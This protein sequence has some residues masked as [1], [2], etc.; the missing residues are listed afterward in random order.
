MEASLRI[1]TTGENNEQISFPNQEKPIVIHEY[2]YNAQRMGGTPQISFSFTYDECLDNVWTGNEYIVFKGEKYFIDSTPSVEKSNSDARYSYDVTCYSERNILNTV[3]F[4]DVVTQEDDTQIRGTLSFQFNGNIAEFAKR[5]SESM[6]INGVDYSVVVD[7][8][9]ETEYKNISFEHKYFSE[10]INEIYNTYKLRYYF[11][12]K[13]CHVGDSNNTVDHIFEYGS[14]EGLLSVNH[15]NQNASVITRIWGNG[16]SDNIPYYYPNPTGKGT[17]TIVADENNEGASTDD[18][19]VIDQVKFAEKVALSD[20]LYYE[21]ADATNVWVTLDYPETTHRFKTYIINEPDGNYSGRAYIDRLSITYGQLYTDYNKFYLK[22]ELTTL[23]KNTKLNWSLSIIC[24]LLRIPSFGG[25]PPDLTRPFQFSGIVVKINITNETGD[26][27]YNYEHTFEIQDKGDSTFRYAFNEKAEFITLFKTP[28]K[29]I[30]DGTIE[31]AYI[32]PV[33]SWKFYWMRIEPLS[34]IGF[35]FYSDLDKTVGLYINGDADRKYNLDELG[36]KINSLHYGDKFYQKQVKYITPSDKLMPSIYRES[37]GKEAFY[38]A[39]NNT[40]KVDGKENEYYLFSEEF[41]E[42]KP[43]DG[44]QE[45]EEIKPSIEGMTNAAGQPMTQFLDFAYDTNDSDEID[46]ETNKYLHPYF[47][48]KLPKTNGS[49]GFNLFSQVNEKETMKISFTSGALA[50]CTFEIGV[51]DNT[52]KNTVQVNT[53]GSLQRDE[54]GNVLCGREDVQ[55][56]VEPQDRQNDTLNNEVWIAL[57]KDDSSYSYVM[58]NV[59]RNYKPTTNDTFVILGITMPE[60]YIIAAEKKLDEK[61]ISY[62]SD[63]NFE[64]FSFS[65]S[66]SRIFLA[67]HPDITEQIDENS[68][69]KIRYN[70][71]EYELFI[72]SYTYTKKA[73]DVLP[74]IKVNLTDNMVVSS[75]SLNTAV[76]NAVQNSMTSL[77]NSAVQGEA[78]NQLQTMLQNFLRKDINDVAN[79]TITFLRNVFFGQGGNY[80]IGSDGIASLFNV[81]LSGKIDV[82]NF[83]QGISG[84]RISSDGIARFISLFLSNGVRSTDFNAGVLGTG[85]CLQKDENGDSY[86][87]VDRMLVRKIATFVQLMIQEIKHVGGQIIL[88]PAAMK[89]SNVEAIM[90]NVLRD[91]NGEIL[92]DSNGEMLTDNTDT[93]VVTA[94]RCYFDKSDGERTIYNEFVVGDQVRCQTFNVETGNI[95]YAGNTYYWRLVVGV[96]EDYIDLSVDDCDEGSGIPVIG[97]ELVQLGNRTD[98]T[99]QNA[100]ILS[101]Y[102]EGSPSFIQYKGIN[103]YQLTEDMIVSKISP[104]GNYLK[105]TLVIEAA[106]GDKNVYDELYKINTNLTDGLKEIDEKYSF[107]ETLKEEFEIA[108]AQIDGSITTW[109]YDPVPTLDNAPA[110]EWDTVELKNQH[111]GDLYY[112]G[113]GRAY[114]FQMSGDDYIWQEIVD[115]DITLALEKAKNAQDT[116][117]GKRRVFVNTPTNKSAYDPGDLWV[118]ATYEDIYINDLLRCNTK[119]AEDEPWKISHWEKASKYTDDTLAKAAAKAAEDA[120]KAADNANIDLTNFKSDDIISP[121]E[122]TSLEQ[123]MSDIRSEYNEIIANANRYDIDSTNYKT[124]YDAAIAALTKYTSVSPEFINIEADYNNISAYYSARQTILDAIAI[125]THNLVNQ[126]VQDAARAGHYYLDLTNDVAAVS[127]DSEGNVIGTLPNSKAIVYYGTSVDTGW[128]YKGTFS[129][130]SGSVNST[131]GQITLSAVSADNASVTVT[132]TKADCPELTNVFSISKVRQGTV[133]RGI[134]QTDVTYKASSSGTTVPGGTWSTSVPTVPEGQFLWTRTII[135]YNDG[136]DSTSYSVGKIGSTGQPGADGDGIVSVSTTYQIGTSGTTPPSGTWNASVPSPQ[137]GKYLWTRT[138]TSYKQG[139]P[140]TT[141]GVSYYGTDGTAA[142]YVRL[143]GDQTFVYS[144]N[145]S[146]NPTP[147]SIKLTATLTG[148]SG[149]QWSYKRASQSSFTNISGATSQTY[150]LSHNNST[151]WGSDKSVTL[152]CTSGGVHDEMTVVKVSS[153]SNGANGKDA[154]T[155]ILSNESHAFQGTNNAAIAA[156]VKCDVIAYKGAARVAAT[157]GDITGEPSGMTTS[158]SGNGSTTAAF[159]VSVTSAFTT[160]NG[161]L[162]IPITVDGQSFT[163][164]FSFSIAFKGESGV[165]VESVANKYAV[166][167]SNTTAPTSWSDNVPTMTTTNKYLWNYEIITY[168]NGSTD[169]TQKRVIGVHGNTGTAGNGIKSISERY[170][171]STSSSGVTTSTSGWTET[172]QTTTSSKRYLWNYEIITY[173]NG[174]RHTSTPVVIGTYG[175]KG[176]AAV[177][178][179]IEPSVTVVKRNMDD[180]ISADTVTCKKYKTTGNTARVE[181]TEKTLKYQRIGQDAS[182]QNYSGAVAVTSSTTMIVFT[183]YDGS[184]VLDRENVPVLLDASGIDLNTRNYANGT[185][186][187]I[188]IKTFLNMNNQVAK[189]EYNCTGLKT[190][191]T[192]TISF[193]YEASG[194]TFGDGAMIRIQPD[195]VYGYSQFAVIPNQNGKGHVKSTVTIKNHYNTGDPVTEN[196]VSAISVRLDYISGSSGA[197]LRIWN[198][199][200][201]KGDIEADWHPSPEDLTPKATFK[202]LSDRVESMVTDIDEVNGAVSEHATL[203]EQ[204]AE[205]I[206]LRATRTEVDTKINGIS[207]GGRNLLMK[208]NQG[209]TNW[210][211]ASNTGGGFTW[212]AWGDGVEFNVNT[213]QGISW[214]YANY[215][216]TGTIPILEPNTDY[217]LSFDV[218]SNVSVNRGVQIKKN[219]ATMSLTTRNS[220]NT[221]ANETVHVSMKL[222]TNGLEDAGTQVLYFEGLGSNAPATYRFKNLKLEKGNKATDWSPA[223]EDGTAALE[224]YKT[225]MAAEIEVLPEKIKSSVTEEI[226]DVNNEKIAGRF[227]TIEQEVDGITSTVSGLNGRVSTIEQT[228][229]DISLK[230][231]S[232]DPVNLFRDG[233]FERGENSFYYVQDDAKNYINVQ[234][235]EGKFGSKCL[236]ID[237]KGGTLS[238]DF[239]QLISVVPGK[240]YTAYMFAKVKASGTAAFRFKF[241]SA[242]KVYLEIAVVQLSNCTE[243]TLFKNTFTTPSGAVYAQPR[244]QFTGS[245][246]ASGDYVLLDGMMLFAGDDPYPDIDYY[247]DN[248]SLSAESLL[249]TGIDIENKKVT[250]TADRFEVRNNSGEVTARVNDDGLLQVGSGE[251]S[252]LIRQVPFVVEDAANDDRLT[253]DGE[254]YIE[255]KEE[256]LVTGGFIVINQTSNSY[257]GQGINLPV[258]LRYAGTRIFIIKRWASLGNFTIRTVPEDLPDGYT[259]WRDESALPSKELFRI[260]NKTAVAI[261]MGESGSWDNEFLELVAMP[262]MFD[263]GANGRKAYGYV[264]W[265][266]MNAWQWS[267]KSDGGRNVGYRQNGY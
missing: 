139:D 215:D 102:G 88:T 119:K 97:D 104:S 50:G 197:Y 11:D 232:I 25:T 4:T 15:E 103:S 167:S 248:N 111:L 198:F 166:S 189:T 26:N 267:V 199:M 39:Y 194:L 31:L 128:T 236:R 131:S 211:I 144:N 13:V 190:G 86:L 177:I 121:V 21:I 12:G 80:S 28:G 51:G 76:Q 3:F 122:K 133:G 41:K 113:E 245:G 108:K 179:S 79:G 250:V 154:Y 176:D 238:A 40:Y 252:G 127:S 168:T 210:R 87:E 45:F 134:S 249:D 227:S 95:Y 228:A 256:N 221:V 96:G 7:E 90:E 254:N 137:K 73:N 207:I 171:A 46:S 68:K 193:D 237:G 184:V 217:M 72:S 2:E 200:V 23:L 29:Y 53:D 43:Q 93:D 243:W 135:T 81:L 195:T 82:G 94:Y 89:C 84:A 260:R 56:E 115:N 224:E 188:E 251:F 185:Y 203:I 49:N 70:G 156:S 35:L 85:F 187:R 178:Y 150:T 109:F 192:V 257:V 66:F 169:E 264:E 136:T 69:L 44:Y 165:G 67:E 101:A 255:L 239:N 100:I 34:I 33:N 129:G 206:S 116:A 149:Y 201:N 183:L 191:D 234:A 37:E 124:A 246:L 107:T 214:M 62:M 75:S 240:T 173:T 263:A 59:Q 65:I 172:V 42:D 204:N 241:L 99:R 182:E 61:L 63:N 225:D 132:A 24:G 17:L 146:G 155:V 147:T 220:Y 235:T 160:G 223:P 58:P 205:Q 153:G 196:D 143:A 130:C 145:F 152:R 213:I 226:Y 174:D 148:T 120:Q 10:A 151:I 231:A 106:E 262:K 138:V 163:K 142:K 170:L 19:A 55:S 71:D 141:Y 125:K 5:L 164:N 83:V 118:N 54:A 181:T 218:W 9:I 114:R 244:I 161:I 175:D 247:V 202:V 30:I 16:S 233:A 140:T 18:C 180:T 57:K 261:W 242:A 216:L 60:A 20:Y 186:D 258:G 36:L 158:I 209:R 159:T 230:V 8:G 64:K 78:E 117:D 1:Y 229:E 22:G 32:A 212:N 222:T 91:S 208:T 6:K 259:E 112:S 265:V 123:Q 27:I 162:K 14:K 48:A 92:Y 98:R 38:E 110:S 126:A 105:G 52:E 157:I 266:V 74:E 253:L 47:F 77:V 219:D